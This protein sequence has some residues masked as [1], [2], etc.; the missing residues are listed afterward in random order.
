MRA[1]TRS[2]L[3]AVLLLAATA[4][5]AAARG[6]VSDVNP[7]V[8]TMPGA[9]DFGTG[10]GA[11]NT[12]PGATMPFGMVVAQPRHDPGARASP[13][14]GYADTRLRGFSLTHFSGAGCAALRD[15]PHPAHHR[16]R[17]P[18]PPLGEGVALDAGP[19]PGD[20]SPP[21]RAP[22]PAATA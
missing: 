22:R 6:L 17:S 18:A 7:F 13:R 4:P 11:G 14:Y 1:A 21:S 20:R 15:V 12:F 3:T 16:R 19:H 2:L 5:G 10:G 9:A 8:G